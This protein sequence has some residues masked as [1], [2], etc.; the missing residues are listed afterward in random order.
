MGGQNEFWQRPFLIFIYFFAIYSICCWHTSQFLYCRTRERR[1]KKDP[2]PNLL[3]CLFLYTYINQVLGGRNS[4]RKGNK[5]LKSEILQSQQKVICFIATHARKRRR[6]RRRR[7]TEWGWSEW[8]LIGSELPELLANSPETK[9]NLYMK[10]RTTI[11]MSSFK[12]LGDKM[13]SSSV[14][15]KP[16][17]LANHLYPSLSHEPDLEHHY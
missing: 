3:C 17:K 8:Q 10:Q 13:I 5:C 11:L 15:S 14:Y 9:G 2:H 4:C 7:I 16:I 1:K 6:R 12:A